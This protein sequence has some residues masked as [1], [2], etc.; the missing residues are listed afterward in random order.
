MTAKH[1]A[2]SGRAGTWTR[3]IGVGVGAL[4]MLVGGLSVFLIDWRRVPPEPE[5]L[6]RPLKTLVVG[7]VFPEVRTHPARIR[8][9]QEVTL[10]FE[11]PGVVRELPVLRGER[12]EAGQLL[13]QLDLRDFRSRLSSAEARLRQASVE[14][15]ATSQARERG[16]VSEMEFTRTSAAVELAQAEFDLA[17]KAL[18]DATLLAPFDGIVADIFVDRFTNVAARTR[19]LRLQDSGAVRMEVNVPESRVA[20]ARRYEAQASFEAR[21]D[22]LPGRS[23]EAALVEFTT[24]ADPVTQTFRAVFEIEPPEE[25]VILPGMTATIVEHLGVADS[26]PVRVPLEAV[27]FTDEGSASVW[28]VES[29]PD[30]TGVVRAVPVSVGEV[31]GADVVILAGIEPGG[32]IAGAG[33]GQLRDGQR[34]RP[35]AG[36]TPAGRP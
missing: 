30:G 8:A 23:F 32:V 29:S 22:F 2:G 21:F 15:D 25:A 3:W 9:R 26:G 24:E 17:E 35:L 7:G 1:R 6:V 20:F 10:A 14:L 13:A 36:E 34:V 19:V 4:L 28:V 16:A 5:P 11:V 31:T 33:V 18:E 12:V 27:V